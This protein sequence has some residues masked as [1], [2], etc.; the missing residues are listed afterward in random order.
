MD[1]SNH[2]SKHHRIYW[3]TDPG[4]RLA[5][6]LNYCAWQPTLDAN[7]Q[8]ADLLVPPAAAT[9][10]APSAA[11]LA[12][13]F[14]ALGDR[15]DALL[16]S[17]R[18]S[19]PPEQHDNDRERH[20]AAP[21]AGASFADRLFPPAAADPGDQEW[22]IPAGPLTHIQTPEETEWAIQQLLERL[23]RELEEALQGMHQPK[24]SDSEFE[25]YRLRV[26]EVRRAIYEIENGGSDV[27]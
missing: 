18:Q 10:P 14:A 21:A 8:F 7:I 3:L 27:D 26:Q 22:D 16:D 5:T 20:A 2:S 4:K 11:D 24:I 25:E 1:T 15:V 13:R 19:L 17:L 23:H 9:H 12:Y 6:Y